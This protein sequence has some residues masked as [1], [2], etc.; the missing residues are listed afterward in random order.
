MILE[1]RVAVGQA[2]ELVQTGSY[3]NRDE[4]E[5]WNTYVRSNAWW[6]EPNMAAPDR[7]TSAYDYS[8]YQYRIDPGLLQT[9]VMDAARATHGLYMGVINANRPA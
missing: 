7:P 3:N 8:S 5:Q 1:D 4:I 6:T 2:G 9:A